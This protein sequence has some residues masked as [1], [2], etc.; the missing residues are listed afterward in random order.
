MNKCENCEHSFTYIPI[1]EGNIYQACRLDNKAV[2]AY[3]CERSLNTN[4]TIHKVPD[5]INDGIL[6]ILK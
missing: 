1:G 6:K 3:G 5:I 2:N 4:Y